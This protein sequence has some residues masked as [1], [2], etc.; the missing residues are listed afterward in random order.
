MFNGFGQRLQRDVKRFTDYRHEKAAKLAAGRFTPQKTDVKVIKYNYQR[1]A[2]WYG[3]SV[4]AGLPAFIQFCH[5]KQEYEE[6]GPAVC[7]YNHVFMGC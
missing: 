7:R 1:Y 2:V 4:M 6:K 3:G 5:T